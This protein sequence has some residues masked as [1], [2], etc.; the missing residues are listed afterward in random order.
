MIYKR[1][2]YPTMAVATIDGKPV[3]GKDL[4]RI[5]RQYEKALTHSM[6]PLGYAQ[7]T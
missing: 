3:V 2:T 6:K 4:A 7:T 1:I 5:R